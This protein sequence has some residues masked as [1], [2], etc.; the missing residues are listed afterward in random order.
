MR[1][2]SQILSVRAKHLHV[3]RCDRF[4]SSCWLILGRSSPLASLWQPVG[5]LST[6]LGS[7]V[8]QGRKQECASPW[9]RILLC[10]AP[11][12]GS[13]SFLLVRQPLAAQF[14]ASLC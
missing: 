5:V 7:A 11:A 12:P 14:A 3:M 13:A 10:S 2:L 1:R 9:Q 6:W 8:G 4:F